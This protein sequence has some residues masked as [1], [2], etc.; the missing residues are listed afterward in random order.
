MREKQQ[1]VNS[2]PDGG[3]SASEKP[4]GPSRFA[5]I[6]VA[7]IRGAPRPN[8]FFSGASASRFA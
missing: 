5:L 6:P 4:V 2:F 3:C 7:G 8:G 1:F